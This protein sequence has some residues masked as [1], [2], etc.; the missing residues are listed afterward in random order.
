MFPI[1]KELLLVISTVIYVVQVV[2]GKSH[3]S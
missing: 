2:F 1:E 3:V